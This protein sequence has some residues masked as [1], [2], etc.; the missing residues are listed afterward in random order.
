MAEQLKGG[1]NVAV[2]PAQPENAQMTPPEI[3]IPPP[4]DWKDKLNSWLG[5]AII[6]RE[7][8]E[9][10]DSA[11]IETT[12]DSL[13]IRKSSADKSIILKTKVGHIKG[14]VFSPVQAQTNAV[15]LI[16]SMEQSD[17]FVPR[18]TREVYAGTFVSGE[19]F[20]PAYTFLHAHGITSDPSL[21]TLF[22]PRP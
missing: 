15:D 19:A 20:Q 13:T 4:A 17:P 7:R 6:P 10:S 3:L 14:V 9:L 11:Q 1:Y 2:V 18:K 16:L 12:D 22:G 8:W 21:S 5:L